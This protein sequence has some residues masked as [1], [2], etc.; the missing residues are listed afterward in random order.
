V[1]Q[2]LIRS[3]SQNVYQRSGSKSAASTSAGH[4]V[5][6]RR[7]DA[8]R[9]AGHPARIGGAPEHVIR[10]QVERDPPVA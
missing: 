10:M 4:A 5:Q 1:Y 7:D 9:G 2:T 3:L 6:Q 8:V